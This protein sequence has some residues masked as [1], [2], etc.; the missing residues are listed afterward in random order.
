VRNLAIIGPRS[1]TARQ[2]GSTPCSSSRACGGKNQGVGPRH[3][4]DGPG[5]RSAASP[6]W[7]SRP[8]SSTGPAH[9]H[10]RPPG[11]ADLGVEVER[12]CRCRLGTPACDASEGAPCPRRLLA[13]AK[14]WSGL[15]VIPIINKI[16]RPDA[17]IAEVPATSTASDRPSIP[18]R[19]S[20]TDP[21]LHRLR[22]WYGTRDM[23]RSPC[24]LVPL[25]EV[26]RRVTPH[27]V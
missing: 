21:D 13:C 24:R 9:Q 7:L 5:A 6:S 2:R 12:T 26:N 8:P 22:K 25:F 27:P 11:H 16:D 15:P 17:R 10:L 19:A 1:T 4:L 3:G 23:R 18:T 14:A 20:S